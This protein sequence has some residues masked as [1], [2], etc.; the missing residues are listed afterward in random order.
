M[1]RIDAPARWLR[2]ACLLLGAV[3]VAAGCGSAAESAAP[4]VASAAAATV[5]PT[6]TA[7]VTPSPSPVDVSAV[8]L[9][10]LSSPTFSSSADLSG[11]MTIGPLKGEIS[12]D[13]AFDGKDSSM[14]MKIVAGSFKQDTSQIQVGDQAWAMKAP[15]PW[16]EQ[17]KKTSTS[18]G[19]SIGDILRSL[20]KVTD[21]GIVTKSG[22]SLHHLQFAGA[23]KF[24]G[25]TIGLD[26]KGTK[27]STFSLDFYATDA[28]VPA[29]MTMSGTWT[30]VSATAD[31]PCSMTF[32]ITF[33]NVGAPQTITPPTDV[34]TV[35]ASKLGYSMAHP[36]D[37]TVKTA[38]DEDTY[39]VG[40]QGYVYVATSSYKGSTAKFAA[41]LKASY[42]KPF[43]G[44]P[45]SQTPTALGGVA[46]IRLIYQFKNS[47]NQDVTL[48]DDVVSRDGTGWEVSL[49]TGGGTQDIDVFDQFVA[50][51]AFTE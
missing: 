19:S 30:Q 38:K 32:D 34:W 39:A 27:D 17:P 26:P 11:S 2:V 13:A 37:W 9:T 10:T 31:V 41:D 28:G 20:I 23:N 25:A 15:G 35:Y 44:D 4:S 8:F 36:A 40:G 29:I 3:L 1:T 45:A 42:K 46:A 50:T 49:V 48:V 24:S 47:T 33:T 6:P 7:L 51:F 16:L 22:Q 43:K 21:L 12:G 5:S 18:S 14:N